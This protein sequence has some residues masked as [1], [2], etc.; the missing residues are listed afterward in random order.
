M[1]NN[2]ENNKILSARID[3]E[4][5]AI[6]NKNAQ[7]KEQI[8]ELNEKI[9]SMESESQTLLDEFEASHKV[10]SDLNKE[11]SDCKEKIDSINREILEKTNEISTGKAN[12]SGMETLRESHLERKAQ[13]E[14]ERETAIKGRE[15]TLSEIAQ[16]E[17]SV[18]ELYPQIREVFDFLENIN[19]SY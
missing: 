5:E 2:I 9:D 4:I 3:G 17:K 12:I 18:E 10:N 7:Y 8:K 1:K 19:S 15:N 13:M 6:K 16:N 11:L 14:A